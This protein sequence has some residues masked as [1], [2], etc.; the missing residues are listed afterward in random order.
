MNAADLIAALELPAGVRIDQ[1]VPKK[2]L[3]ENG[4]P[5]SADK[6]YI[7]EGIEELQWIAALKPTTIGV[8][9]YRDEVRE[10]LEIAVLQLTLRA[11]ANAGRIVSL[12]H[13][14]VP[15]PV[16]LF[17]DKGELPG[18][19]A[20]HKRWSLGEAG[21]TVLDGDVVAVEWEKTY[22]SAFR[23][24]LTLSHQPRNTLY[25]LYQGWFDTLLSLQAAQLTGAF[26]KPASAEH[27]AARH[28]A[29]LECARLEAEIARLRSAAEKEKQLPRKVELNLELKRLQAL[30]AA[31]RAKL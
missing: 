18:V 10:Y 17:T 27:A 11:S 12:V 1:R 14:A 7:N 3:L 16:L 23:E 9:E 19:S 30:Q 24:A 21:K 13:R 5:T 26:V 4:A 29:L 6:R 15:Y 25:S 8:P 28:E 22:D 2:L 31:A 20:A